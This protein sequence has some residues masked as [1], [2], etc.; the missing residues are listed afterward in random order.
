MT[1][2]IQLP[3][4]AAG[5]PSA[6]RVQHDA[7]A[8][9]TDTVYAVFTSIDDT[10]AAVRTAGDF[11]QPLGIPV[12][13]VHFR[14]VPY[15]LAV[16]QPTGISPVD[17]DEF[18]ARLS[19]ECPDVNVRVYLCR[20][21]RQAISMAFKPHSLIVVAGQR[22]WWRTESDWWRTAL[23]VAGHFVVFVDKAEHMEKSHA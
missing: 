11:A 1:P 19:A 7:P 10:L 22:K 18:A 14:T 13:L 20:D 17:T 23:E 4:T 12:T 8:V 16:D 3:S 6:P 15:T 9:R 21:K 2:I 5:N